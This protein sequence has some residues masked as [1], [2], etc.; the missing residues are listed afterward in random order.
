MKQASME[1][2]ILSYSISLALCLL[3]F[4]PVTAQNGI[5]TAP[6]EA[7]PPKK[8]KKDAKERSALSLYNGMSVGLD[9][10]ESEAPYLEE[11]S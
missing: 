2:K 4:P 10:W 11:I 3:M 9:L 5:R 8:E 6:P 7:A 1:R